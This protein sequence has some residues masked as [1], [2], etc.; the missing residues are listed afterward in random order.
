MKKN[1]LLF[2]VSNL[3]SWYHTHDIL[4]KIW[5]SW[6]SILFH[7][8]LHLPLTAFIFSQSAYSFYSDPVQYVLYP[9]PFSINHSICNISP[10]ISLQSRYVGILRRKWQI[11]L[12][13]DFRFFSTIQSR[14]TAMM[15][16]RQWWERKIK[17]SRDIFSLIIATGDY[18]TINRKQMFNGTC[19]ASEMRFDPYNVFSTHLHVFFSSFFFYLIFAGP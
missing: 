11:I 4:Y 10:S 15:A 9:F 1:F 12:L 6:F 3:L 17:V 2:E 14:R 13:A 5:L 19:A 16:Y 8:L 18:I 7:Q